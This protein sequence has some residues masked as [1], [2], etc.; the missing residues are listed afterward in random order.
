VLR[1]GVRQAFI[2]GSLPSLIQR[3]LA[4]LV[5]GSLSRTMIRFSEDLFL[6]FSANRRPDGVVILIFEDV[7]ARIRA[8]R[9]I[10]HIVRFDS[11]TGL[12]N[13]EYFI[14]LVKENLSARAK[15]GKIGIMVLDI[16][17][18]KHVNDTK[19]HVAGDRLLV[20]IA[21]RLKKEAE[22]IAVVARLMGD[23][24]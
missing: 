5:D 4:Q 20:K 24:F 16:D 3:Q 18:F 8:E 15:P 14:E 13:R 17:E 1:Y 9:K 19:G 21:A 12:P 10:L 11:L 7:T 2:D 23:Q 6:E 22:G